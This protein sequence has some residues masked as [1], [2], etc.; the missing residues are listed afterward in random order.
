MKLLIIPLIFA[1]A[2]TDGINAEPASRYK[3]TCE[4][5]PCS[6]DDLAALNLVNNNYG[7][8]LEKRLIENSYYPHPWYWVYKDKSN[9]KYK[10]AVREDLPTHLTTM[11]WIDVDICKKTTKLINLGLRS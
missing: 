9:C 7:K 2:L 6:E 11:E 5:H 10:V 3:L 8:K 1:L 4:D